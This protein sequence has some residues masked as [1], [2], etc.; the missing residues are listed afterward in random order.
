MWSLGVQ[1]DRK[2]VPGGRYENIDG[3]PVVALGRLNA[4]GV[5]D[6]TF[7]IDIGVDG[8]VFAVAVQPDGGIIIGGDFKK[9]AGVDAKNIARLNPDG[10]LDP[11]F[12]VGSGADK[13]VRDIAIQDDGK[14]V[15]VGEFG[16]LSGAAFGKVARLNPDGTADVEFTPGMGANGIV[17]SVGLQQ[18]GGIIV[19]G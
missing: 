7:G 4:D 1:T 10:T 16:V 17:H 3:N 12:A 9:V 5:F 6:D 13:S 18:D 11:T 19:A 2:P 14:L 8:E 15:V